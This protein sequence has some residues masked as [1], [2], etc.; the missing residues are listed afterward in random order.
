MI[1]S[2]LQV[3]T[4]IR[5]YTSVKEN[6]NHN[7]KV[8]QLPLCNNADSIYHSILKLDNYCLTV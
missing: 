4:I 6:D 5:T 7:I 8:K 1:S 3:T 2:Y